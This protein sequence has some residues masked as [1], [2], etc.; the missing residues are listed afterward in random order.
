MCLNEANVTWWKQED[1]A[2]FIATPTRDNSRIN[3]RQS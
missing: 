3:L 2:F 1:K